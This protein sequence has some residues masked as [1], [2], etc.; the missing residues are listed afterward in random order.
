M[1]P[2]VFDVVAYILQQ[3]GP[4]TTW[5]L[6]K[7]VYYSQ[8]WSLV[9]DDDVLFSEEIQAWANGPVVP[10]LYKKHRKEYRV[11]VNFFN[12]ANPD[13]LSKSQKETVDAVLDFYGN[14]SSQWLSDLTHA[15][16]PWKNA[17]V[18]IP[19]GERST[20]IIT[21]ESLVSYYSSLQEK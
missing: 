7:L 4:L 18:G 16:D 6:Q 9:W 14:E 2:N 21:K 8:A 19:N 12:K 1:T 10:K 5:K 15:E 17:R 3:K 20:A 11:N 13:K